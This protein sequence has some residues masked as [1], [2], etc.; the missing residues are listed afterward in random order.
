MA[1]STNIEKKKKITCYIKLRNNYHY[2]YLH[3]NLKLYVSEKNYFKINIFLKKNS[4]IKIS[5]RHVSN[6]FDFN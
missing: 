4:V 5:N 6:I 3:Q 2:S 1:T